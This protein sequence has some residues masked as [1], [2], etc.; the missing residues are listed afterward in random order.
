MFTAM[1]VRASAPTDLG[2]G[3]QPW[4]ISLSTSPPSV[5]TGAERT[6]PRL[7][8]ADVE[9]GIARLRVG[10]GP[11]EFSEARPITGLKGVVPIGMRRGVRLIESGDAIL[12]SAV[13]RGE[14]G[15]QNLLVTRSTDLG[16]TWA[17]PSRLNSVNDSAREGL[18]GVASLG[19]RVAIVWLD[20]RSGSHEVFMSVSRDAGKTFG[21][22]VLVYRSPDG[23]VC[24]C[25]APSVSFDSIGRIVVMFRNQI[26]G[27]RDIH[28]ISSRD[29]GASFDS[30]RKLGTGSWQ[31]SSCPMD[32]GSLVNAGGAL[33][34]V[35][36]REGKVVRVDLSN[37]REQQLAEGAGVF[38]APMKLPQG[39]GIASVYTASD[40]TLSLS[41][42]R[43]DATET[44]NSSIAESPAGESVVVQIDDQL[45]I[46]TES[47]RRLILHRV[48]IAPP[49]GP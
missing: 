28:V 32:G 40:G 49:A 11:D 47:R 21:D 17:E 13:V 31:A 30:L 38:A 18:H 2:P 8:L 3:R 26:A 10:L 27:V 33:L 25:C 48:P 14:D 4:I 15:S 44:I 16:Q 34:S 22:D 39:F 45:L 24:E 37:G 42:A 36:Q 20:V 6:S 9:G 46:V 43:I 29:G 19:G 23:S 1:S 5:G 7:A 41:Q 12:A 35:F